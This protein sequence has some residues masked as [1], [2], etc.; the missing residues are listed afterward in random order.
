[1]ADVRI[2]EKPAFDVMGPKVWIGGQDNEFFGEFWGECEENG[3]LSALQGLN[4]GSIGAQ[5]GSSLL[6]VSRVEADP[7]NRSFYYMIAREVP[8]ATPLPDG[9]ERYQVPPCTWAVF[10]CHGKVPEAIV[11]SEM[12]AFMEWL[13]QSGYEHAPAPEMEVYFPDSDGGKDD[14]YTEFWLPVQKK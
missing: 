14:C 1:M 8:E 5:T 6:G 11:N 7:Q 3:M 4:G 10:A 13:P 12:Y 9:M 2:V